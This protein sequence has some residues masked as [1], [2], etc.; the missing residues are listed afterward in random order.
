M[1]EGLSVSPAVLQ[2]KATAIK[3][4]VSEIGTI[5]GNVTT[6]VGKVPDSFEGK[7]SSEFQQQYNELTK[8]YEK[9][10][11][12]MNSYADFLNK[13]AETYIQ[14]DETIASLA[15]QNLDK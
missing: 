13:T 11:A 1:N 15:N 8:N 14:M 7:A 10:S 4:K 5:L 2:E 9:F 6:E 12:E 3:N